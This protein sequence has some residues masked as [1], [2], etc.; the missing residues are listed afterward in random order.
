MPRKQQE[1]NHVPQLARSFLGNY[2]KPLSAESPGVLK[3][4]IP[5]A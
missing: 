2:A 3:E 4:T 1:K 5:L